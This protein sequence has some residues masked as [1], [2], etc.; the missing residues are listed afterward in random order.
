[1]G[2]IELDIGEATFAFRRKTDVIAA[3]A[4]LD[5]FYV[6]RTNLP[7]RVLGCYARTP[8]GKWKIA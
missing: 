8:A 4:A 6:V 2:P 7:K 3:E 1:M 5:G